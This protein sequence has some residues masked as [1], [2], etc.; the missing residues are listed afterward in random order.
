MKMRKGFTLIELLVVIAIIAILIGL[1]L[2][3][4]QKVRE[5][6]ARMQCQN[7]L[8]QIGLAVM[9]YEA[10]RNNFPRGGEHLAN[11]F[12]T[13]DFQSPL[14]LILPMMEQDNVYKQFDLTVRHNEGINLANAANGQGPGA[15]IK[16]FLCPTNPI[17]TA[18]RDDRGNGYSDYAFLPYVVVTPAAAAAS[19]LSPGFYESACTGGA[20]PLNMYQTYSSAASDVAAFKTYQLLPSSVIGSSI[21][22]NYAAGKISSITD[23]ASN[24]ILVYEDVGR[25]EKMNG[26]GG[27]PNSYVDPVD[28]QGRRHWRWAEPDNSSG[29]SNVIN[30]NNTPTWGPQSCPWT[31]HD[32]GPNNEWFSF[33]GGGAHAVFADGHVAFVNEGVKLR[34]VF[35]MGTRSGG[36]VFDY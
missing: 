8:K 17:R 24:S 14:T 10:A 18:S 2:P 30:N 35:S 22:L 1:L 21:D 25:S 27:P 15:V 13:Q 23:G 6:A 12:R 33:H 28:G 3:A 7:N 16:S 20:Y 26:T 29:C 9:N 32:C 31:A 5:A 34:V 36:E 19:G 4:V 11:G